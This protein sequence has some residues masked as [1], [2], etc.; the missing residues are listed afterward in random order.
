MLSIFS[1]VYIQISIGAPH[2]ILWDIYRRWKYIPLDVEVGPLRI[3]YKFLR[4]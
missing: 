2:L 1:R 3:Y 4:V